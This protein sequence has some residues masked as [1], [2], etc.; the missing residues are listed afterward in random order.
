MRGRGNHPE[1]PGGAGLLRS[2][3]LPQAAANGR[4]QGEVVEKEEETRAGM[5]GVFS[6]GSSRQWDDGGD[7]GQYV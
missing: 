3:C 6:P 1:S 4:R 7:D 2:A 5:R